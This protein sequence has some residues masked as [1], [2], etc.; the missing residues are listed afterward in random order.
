[1]YSILAAGFL[2]MTVGM[3]LMLCWLGWQQHKIDQAES[4]AKQQK[5]ADAAQAA[6]LLADGLAKPAV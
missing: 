3:T 4:Q 1:M 6:A 5:R 2:V